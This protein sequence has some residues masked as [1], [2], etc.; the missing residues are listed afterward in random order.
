MGYEPSFDLIDEPWLAVL[1]H[2]A[3]RKEVSLRELFAGAQ[4]ARQLA[5]ELPTQ[6]F[7]VL[8][9]LIAILQR[10]VFQARAD[11]DPIDVWSDLWE[12]D[13]LPLDL[14]DAY[15]ERHRQRFDLLHPVTPFF[16]VAGLTTA[17]GP[18]GPVKKLVAD[19]PD[20]HQFFSSRS[21]LEATRLAFGEAARWLVHLQAFDTAGIKSGVLGDPTVKGGKSYPIGTG[22]AGKL[23]GVYAEGADLRQTLL[24][25]LVLDTGAWRRNP[26]D[27]PLWELEPQGADPTAPRPAPVGPAGLYT[28]AARAVRLIPDDGGVVGAVLTN[29]ARLDQPN[30]HQLEPM[31]AWRRSANQERR[32]RLETVFMPLAHVP[33]RALWRGLQAMLPEAQTASTPSLQ[34]PLVVNWI[35]GLVLEGVLPADY[36]VG[37]SAAALVYGSNN[38]VV[39]GSVDDSILIHAAL[40]DPDRPALRELA[41]DAVGA[42][43]AAVSSLGRLATNIDLAGGSRDSH[44]DQAARA[45]AYF[46]LDGPFRIWLSRI[47]AGTPLAEAKAEWE[48]TVAT[49]LIRIAQEL[50]W[51]AAPRA[52]QGSEVKRGQGGSSWMTLGKAMALFHHGLAR[53]LPNRKQAGA[54]TGEPVTIEGG[55]DD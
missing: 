34:A 19:V 7:A 27:L 8:R 48:T 24:L 31:S 16:Q 53:S 46:R 5:G 2:G 25:N 32:L 49:T 14:I 36:P 43:D 22:W 45:Q 3:Q 33:E 9:L 55:K 6:N 18:P 52:F 47:G 11:D 21:G 15:L 12:A 42:A 29:G 30:R 51:E 35:A 4:A 38:S 10:S 54:A 41:V 50:E 20:G 40:L 23:G 44:A 26:P 39:S 37:L 28:W 1:D 17:K 13:R